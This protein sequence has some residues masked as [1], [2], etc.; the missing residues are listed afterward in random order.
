MQQRIHIM[1]TITNIKQYLEKILIIFEYALLYAIFYSGACNKL[2]WLEN[3]L[4]A[5][6]VYNSEIFNTRADNKMN[7]DTI[8]ISQIHLKLISY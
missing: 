1:I 5:I 8:L 7:I 4:N 2:P 3:P 6:I